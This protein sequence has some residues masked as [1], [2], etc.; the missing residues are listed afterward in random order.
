MLGPIPDPFKE[1][2]D[3]MPET[4]PDFPRRGHPQPAGADRAPARAAGIFMI[5]A[6]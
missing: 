4:L 3:P 6:G 1:D 5:G 2:R